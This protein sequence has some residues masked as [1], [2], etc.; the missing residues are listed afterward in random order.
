MKASARH[1]VT[2][3]ITEHGPHLGMT[4]D[5][6]DAPQWRGDF[7]SDEPEAW[8]P[9][10]TP[11]DDSRPDTTADTT[12]GTIEVTILSGPREGATAR[13][14]LMSDGEGIAHLQG[15][16]PFHPPA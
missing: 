13:A 12:P 9:I 10:D 5:D 14:R 4:I 15:I 16:E 6:P 8:A 11:G 2:V 7:T 3:Q 1:H